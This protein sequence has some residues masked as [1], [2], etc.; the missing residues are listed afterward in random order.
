MRNTVWTQ[1][2]LYT[3]RRA[4][5]PECQVC[6]A[7]AGKKGHRHYG[8]NGGAAE[9]R[10][11]E[12]LEPEVREAAV[13]VPCSGTCWEQLLVANPAADLALPDLAFRPIWVECL[14]TQTGTRRCRTGHLFTN[15]SGFDAQLGLACRV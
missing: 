15:G 6:H 1:G 11:R 4:E 12:F 2:R 7:V 8:C 10:R 3:A 13:V 9:P 5:T 14:T